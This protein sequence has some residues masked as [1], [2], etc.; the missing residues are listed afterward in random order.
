[1]IPNMVSVQMNINK[2][3]GNVILG[4]LTKLIAGREYIID[5]LEG[6]K[7]KISARS[8]YQVNPI[9]TSILYKKVK[10]YAS[11]SGNETV[12]DLYCGIGTIALTLADSA[13]HIIGIEI[14]PEAIADAIENAKL[15]GITNATFLCGTAEELVPELIANGKFPDVIIVDPPRAGCDPQL[16][17]TI[18]Q[19]KPCRLIYVS[20]NPATLARDLKYLCENGFAVI[21]VQPVDMFPHTSHVETVVLITRVEK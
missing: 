17:T 14:V 6:L 5:E 13:K 2:K 19:V 4:P 21:E 16:L 15:N 8:F 7:F 10:E 9:Q 20:C 12:F 18:V 1:K 3:P 11:L